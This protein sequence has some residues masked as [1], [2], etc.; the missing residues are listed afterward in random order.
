[1]LKN[2]AKKKQFVTLWL[3]VACPLDLRFVSPVHPLRRRSHSMDTPRRGCSFQCQCGNAGRDMEIQHAVNCTS[4]CCSHKRCPKLHCSA[5]STVPLTGQ[6]LWGC[7]NDG[8]LSMSL[9]C[10]SWRI[11]GAAGSCLRGG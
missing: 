2:D 1:M 11:H 10:L 4:A 6:S 7:W 5:T 8:P 3:W 9:R